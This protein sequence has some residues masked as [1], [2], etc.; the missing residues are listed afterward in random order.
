MGFQFMN[1]YRGIAILMVILAHSISVLGSMNPVESIGIS[2]LNLHM[3]NCTL[4]FVTVAGYFFSVL[5]SNYSYIPFLKNK[6]KAVVV[7]YFFVSIPM[8]ILYIFDLKHNHRWVDLEWF[9]SSLDPVSQYVFLMMTGAHL[10]PLWFVPMIVIFYVASPAFIF[11]QRNKGLM[12][13]FLLS[14]IFGAYVGRPEFNENAFHSFAYFL[15]AFFLGML[16]SE[17][18]SLYESIMKY[19]EILIFIYAILISILYINIE[20]NTSVDLFIKLLLA[21]LILALCRKR[22]NHKIVWLDLF[23]R[24]S[25]YLFFVHGYFTGLARIAFR[26]TGIQFEEYSALLFVFMYTVLVSLAGY[27]VCKLILKDQTKFV[28]GA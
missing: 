24:L 9:H 25:F 19:S 16:L 18:K 26:E 23:A 15:P 11:I 21:F 10:G 27:V 17:R 20:I 12:A 13:A 4:L 3:D 14:L 8:I 1:N 28:L 5:S 22:I 7:P 6:F 2:L